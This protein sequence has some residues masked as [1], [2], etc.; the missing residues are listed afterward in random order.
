LQIEHNNQR[1]LSFFIRL[2]NSISIFV[3]MKMKFQIKIACVLFMLTGC[4]YVNYAQS[5]EIIE[6][7]WG[8]G[9][10]LI[11]GDK[12][13]VVPHI[14]DQDMDGNI[15]NFFIRKKIKDNTTRSTNI[16][17]IS[18]TPASAKEIS[19]LISQNIEVSDFRYELKVSKSREKRHVVLNLFPFLLKNGQIVKVDKFN[20]IE[21][22]EINDSPNLLKAFATNSA[23]KE[24]S[25][26]WYKI[27]INQDGIYKLDKTFLEECNIDV[28]NLNPQHIHI[29]GNG[30]GRIPELN[31]IPRT[32]DLAE[33]SIMI[34]D[35]GDG[36]F[37]DNDYVLFYGE[38]PHKWKSVDTS[39]YNQD[40]NP[41]SDVSCYFVNINGSTPPKIISSTPNG[42]G[43]VT[44]NVSTYSYYAVHESDANSLIKAGQRWYGELYDDGTQM[45][46][47]YQFNV[48]NIDN[49]V[50][51]TFDV[52]IASNATFSAGSSHTYTANGIQ[53]GTSQMPSGAGVGNYK[54]QE[55]KMDYANPSSSINLLVSMVK[56]SPDVL[57]YM[58]RILL[59]ARRNLSMTNNQYCSR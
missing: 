54:R 30:E 5:N 59:N 57:T 22:V 56:N 33:N 15:P 6:I 51:A 17:L 21:G 4:V 35:G 10:T 42:V 11:Q 3:P 45:Q 25:G 38:G 40:R 43:V 16:E 26:F 34:V 50:P 19:F 46:Y 32:D 39:S 36:S 14:I 55:M 23:L 31:S 7:P 12:K 2:I 9:K 48:S 37:D 13:I 49:S 24:G 28:E 18:T 41:Y 1:F 52:S 8:E 27:S 20:L 29:F 58:D 53:I 47:N 44:N